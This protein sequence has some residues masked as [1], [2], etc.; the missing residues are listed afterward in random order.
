MVSSAAR[1]VS[2][3]RIQCRSLKQAHLAGLTVWLLSLIHLEYVE[4]FNDNL[5]I[6][7]CKIISCWEIFRIADHFQDIPDKGW[8]RDIEG[9]SEQD[10]QKKNTEG[11][12]TLNWR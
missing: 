11:N 3:H 12:I 7:K 2:F 10:W 1:T 5:A 4:L 6:V 8:F 9:K